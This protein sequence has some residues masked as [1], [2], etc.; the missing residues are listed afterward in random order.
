MDIRAVAFDVNGTL[1]RILTEEGAE[2]IF[3]S[4]AHFLTYQGIHLCRYEVRDLYF[5]ILK[6][7]RQA[8]PEEHP[9]FDA[10]GIWRSIIDAHLTDFTRA[11]PAGK[12]EQMP[13]R[14]AVR[15]RNR[16]GED[17]AAQPESETSGCILHLFGS[18]RG[19]LM[20]SWWRR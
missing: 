14:G 8:S 7:Q 5:Q 20:L 17:P 3:R 6:E 18:M 2:Q 12:L 1:V 16:G 11:L 4:V 15:C 13:R 9:E 19:V 10:A